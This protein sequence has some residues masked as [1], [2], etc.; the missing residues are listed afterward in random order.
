[1]F[2]TPVTEKKRKLK[3]LIIV[4]L[5]ILLALV[6]L[7]VLSETFT[8]KDVDVVGNEHYTDE[9]IT[10]IVIARP[11]ERNSII[12][13]LKYHNKS[14]KDIPFVEQMDVSINSPTSV[15]ITVYEKAVAGYV[16]YLG[17]YM[18]FDKDGI[19]VEGSSMTTPGIPLVTGLTFDHMVLHEKLPVKNEN[20]FRL[21]LSITQLLNKYDISTDKIFFDV[22]ENITLYFGEARVYLGQ[23][24][25][26]DE[27]I[28]EM[29]LL[30][31]E[32]DGY[33]GVLNMENYTGE[34]SVFSFTK[35][36][37]EKNESDNQSQETETLEN[38]E[39]N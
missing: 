12:L 32:L 6:G 14:I 5:I 8:I 31:P 10:S 23:S 17:H 18:Y 4:L 20:I 37:E 9:E 39:E 16:E 11:Y 3:T 25:Y 15:K 1:M 13:F 38:V 26:I 27:K 21:I 34:A 19:V 22:D 35:D 24:D 29:R 2:K 7:L 33:K 36:K 30:L 28:N